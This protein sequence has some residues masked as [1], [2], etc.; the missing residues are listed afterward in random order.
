MDDPHVLRLSRLKVCGS[1]AEVGVGW[2]G[3]GS[4]EIIYSS[5]SRKKYLTYLIL[6]CYSHLQVI[7][8]DSTDF[9]D[10][11]DSSDQSISQQLGEIKDSFI[12][13][14]RL[15]ANK[16]F[17][18]K[19]ENE[20]IDKKFKNSIHGKVKQLQKRFVEF[21][22]QPDIDHK[23]R[24]NETCNDTNAMNDVLTSLHKEIVN[25]GND[26]FNELLDGGVSQIFSVFF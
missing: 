26:T 14:E 24:L 20:S 1:E 11:T 19:I 3:E 21:V 15:I 13:I 8:R 10:S 9:V 6:M 2:W 18:A 12:D 23:Q 17:V 25:G 16:D 22:D 7:E 5:I 4:S